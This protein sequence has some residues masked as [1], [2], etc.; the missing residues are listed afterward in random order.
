V[1]DATAA[2]ESELA[3]SPPSS[4]DSHDSSLTPQEAVS[5]WRQAE[6]I[7]A[8]PLQRATQVGRLPV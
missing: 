7:Y 1:Q 3:S 4:L 8:S 6:T 2:A 5:R